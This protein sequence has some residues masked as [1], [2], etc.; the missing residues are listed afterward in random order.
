MSWVKTPYHHMGRMKGVGV[1][2]AQLLAAVAVN[3]GVADHVETVDYPQD[4]HFHQ[5]PKIFLAHV[6]QYCDLVDDPLD[7]EIVLFWYGRDYAHGAIIL[8]WPL[9]IHASVSSGIVEYIDAAQ[10]PHLSKCA[11]RFYRIRGLRDE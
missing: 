9:C 3:I 6:E 2:C 11:K 10:D 1:D 4:W 5:S 8:E 7:A